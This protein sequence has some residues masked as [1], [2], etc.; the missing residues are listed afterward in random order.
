MTLR[1][2]APIPG[3]VGVALLVLAPDPAQCRQRWLGVILWSLC[4]IGWSGVGPVH[5]PGL[6]P[7]APSLARLLVRLVSAVPSMATKKISH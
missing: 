3:V 2:C 1:L 5:L 6:Q 7:G 4:A